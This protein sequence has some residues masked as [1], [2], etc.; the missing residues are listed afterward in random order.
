MNRI[1][2]AKILVLAA[3]VVMLAAACNRL[4]GEASDY[5]Q[6]SARLAGKI[7]DL[8]LA[9]TPD[10]R[11]VGLGGRSGIGEAQ[12]L[13]FLFSAPGYYEFWMK[14]MRFSIDI[15][16]INGDRIVDIKSNIEPEPDKPEH[17]LVRYRPAAVADK[18]L[19]LRSGWADR[20]GVRVGDRIDITLR[21]NQP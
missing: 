8:D 13:L 21:Q 10:E 17:Q 12:G 3:G 14:D 7:I 2:T 19:E 15:L 16:W 5:N 11:A 9:Q 1:S 4:P 6:G 18:A 20:H